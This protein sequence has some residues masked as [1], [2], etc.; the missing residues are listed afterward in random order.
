MVF[1]R[2]TETTTR[3]DPHSHARSSPDMPFSSC[4]PKTGLL[5]TLGH[6]TASTLFEGD[7]VMFFCLVMATQCFSNDQACNY[8]CTN[9]QQKHPSESLI[10]ARRNAPFLTKRMNPSAIAELVWDVKRAGYKR[11]PR[12]LRPAWSESAKDLI[13]R[14]LVEPY[15]ASGGSVAAYKYTLR[16]N[17]KRGLFIPSNVDMIIKP[18]SRRKRLANSDNPKG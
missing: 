10:A 13:R 1:L 11:A 6:W 17:D 9:A 18:Q 14:A 16:L 5:E 15:L 8:Q 12:H 4:K 3:S 7:C 2:K